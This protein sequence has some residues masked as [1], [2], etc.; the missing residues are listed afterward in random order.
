MKNKKIVLFT[1]VL[2][3]AAFIV[4]TMFYQKSVD[5]KT[6][7]L[8]INNKGAPFVRAHSPIFGNNTK[9]VTI[10]EFMDPE[11]E[12]CSAFHP[13]IKEAF[14][15]YKNETRLVYRY[16][17]NHQ[18]SKFTVKLLEAA[19]IQDKFNEAL[20]IIFK[21]QP[22]WA[23]HNNEQPELLWKFLPEAGLDMIKLKADF[24]TINV[25]SILE[26]DRLDSDKLGV[27]GTPTFFVNGKILKVYTY[28]ALL[29]LIESEIYK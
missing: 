29:D 9:N 17:A 6:Q 4:A 1:L 2:L 26:L 3:V 18:N 14:N 10:V 13:A 25:D 8:A 16:I 12:S 23:E 27:T 28:Q 19:R 15:D 24:E 22:Q 7:Q 11:C 21:Y 5:T 20:E